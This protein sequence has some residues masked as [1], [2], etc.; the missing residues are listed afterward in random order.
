MGETCLKSQAR[1]IAGMLIT[2]SSAKEDDSTDA[3]VGE[4]EAQATNFDKNSRKD[5]LLI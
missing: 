3:V 2:R 4:A 1:K 5:D